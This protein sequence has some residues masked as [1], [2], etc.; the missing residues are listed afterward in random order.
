[1]KEFR[2]KE[3][4]TREEFQERFSEFAALINSID[5]LV[6]SR[7]LEGALVVWNDAFAESI[8]ASFGVEPYVGMKTVDYLAPDQRDNF[9]Q[10]QKLFQQVLA[11]EKQIS[12]F[13]YTLPNGET[14]YF[15][16]R[17]SPIRKADKVIGVVEFTQNITERKKIENELRLSDERFRA[18]VINSSEAIWCFELEQP[19]NICLPVDEQIELAYK[20]AYISEANDTYARFLGYEKGKELK[21]FR[22]DDFM[23]RSLP[24]SINTL[25]QV[26]TEQYNIVNIETYGT[27]KH[28]EMRMFLNNIIGIVEEGHLLRAWGTLRDITEQKEAEKELKESQKDLRN[29]AG[30]LLSVQEEERRRLARELHDDLTQRLAVLAID[31]GKLKMKQSCSS[32]AAGVL[33]S[34][35]EK[36]I[37]ISEDVHSISRQ[38]HPSIIEDLGLE[39]GLRS[40]INNFSQREGIPVSFESNLGSGNLPLDIVICLFRITQE[41]LRNIKKHSKAKNVTIK[42]LLQGDTIFLKIRDNGQ[43]FDPKEVRKL[44]GLGLKSMRERIRLV[45]GSISYTSQPNQGTE[46]SAE[47][48]RHSSRDFQSNNSSEKLND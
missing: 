40:E 35:Q 41:S 43:G 25:R 36:L 8:R 21:G 31:A 13:T 3:H 37:K 4:E 9:A 23:P 32:E 19:I 46:V 47:V 28:G 27:D 12:E 34:M 15:D 7:D 11:G 14:N 18:F 42:L 16:I 45:N 29:L 24:E 39:D 22:L 5:D 48:N 26:V 44:P 33:L 6:C 1:M 10:Q 20:H 30:R 17:W 38:L 2:V